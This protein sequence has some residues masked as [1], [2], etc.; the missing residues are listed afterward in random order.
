[1]RSEILLIGEYSSA[2]KA[3]HDML[4]EQGYGV[5]RAPDFERAVVR[6]ANGHP[7]AIILVSCS[8]S[9]TDQMRLSE[10]VMEQL[11]D[12]DTLYITDA[13][14]ASTDAP[15]RMA[16]GAESD[17]SAR[18]VPHPLLHLPCAATELSRRLRHIL[19]NQAQRR[20]L[21]TVTKSD[22]IA[23][24]SP[25]SRQGTPANSDCS[26]KGVSRAALGQSTGPVSGNAA[27]SLRVLL[28]EDNADT[29]WA[30]SELL[31]AL[32]HRVICAASAEEAIQALAAQDFDVMCSDVGLPGMSGAE[33][34]EAVSRD[35]PEL[36]IVVASGYGYH[37]RIDKE[38]LRLEVLPK[39]YTMA[40]LQAALLNA[41]VRRKGSNR[42]LDRAPNAPA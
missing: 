3:L 25:V 17:D 9:Q 12:T 10:L 40:A 24:V 16:H 32:G 7:P 30:T 37:T 6:I 39:P 18:W 33:L 38:R 41:V 42:G 36:G 8:L 19:N 27:P 4:V 13:A 28:V 29:R 15:P 23:P 11:P 20:M 21:R 5:A 34:A 35:Y 22:A 1:M 31:A 2:H 26:A 14:A